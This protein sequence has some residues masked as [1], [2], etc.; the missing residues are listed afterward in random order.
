MH[1]TNVPLGVIEGEIFD[2]RSI[3][4]ATGDVF[5]FY[6]D[7]VTEARDEHGELFGAERLVECV[8]RNVALEP[9]ALVEAVRVAAQV[10]SGTV[11]PH[12]DL[13]CVAVK[14]VDDEL[15]L[16]QAELELA[17]DL[18]E[19]RRAR[20]FVRGFC[21]AP[22]RLLETEALDALELAVDEAIANIVKHAYGGRTDQRI[23][24]T[25]EAYRD[26][27]AIHLRYVGKAFDRRDVAPPALDGSRESGFGVFMIESSVD[28]VR[29]R[30]DE[31]G[32]NCIDLEKKRSARKEGEDGARDR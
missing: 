4:F 17:S 2:Q 18:A 26:H 9:A 7:G 14:I 5:L 1:G 29:Y 10:F 13:T 21:A 6:S 31:L 22:V 15:P 23:H 16:V 28:A 27:L 3:P 11:L 30:R 8:E 12:D 24:V 32:R 20:Q 19:L 25:A